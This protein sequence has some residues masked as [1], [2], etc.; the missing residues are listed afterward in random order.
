MDLAERTIWR[1]VRDFE[2][3]QCLVLILF[4]FYSVDRMRGFLHVGFSIRVLFMFS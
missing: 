1:A 2:V 3:P 4:I